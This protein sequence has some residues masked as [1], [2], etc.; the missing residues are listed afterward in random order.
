MSEPTPPYQVK[1]SLAEVKIHH[2]SN[3]EDLI[4]HYFECLT[5]C[6]FDTHTCKQICKEELVRY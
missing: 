5:L 4:T 6:D 1:A 2:A 3:D